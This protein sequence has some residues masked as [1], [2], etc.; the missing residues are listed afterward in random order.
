[1]KF[2]QSPII[3]ELLFLNMFSFTPFFG[4]AWGVGCIFFFFFFHNWRYSRKKKKTFESVFSSH[5]SAELVE[6]AELSAGSWLKSLIHDDWSRLKITKP[7]HKHPNRGR[8]NLIQATQHSVW[9]CFN[10]FFFP[11]P[12][13]APTQLLLLL[14]PLL[15]LSPASFHSHFTISLWHLLRAS[16]SQ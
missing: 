1:M 11:F 2:S 15:N 4:G 16:Y 7:P 10:V 6:V 8:S 12:D 13:S 14:L 5:R 3:I 9:I